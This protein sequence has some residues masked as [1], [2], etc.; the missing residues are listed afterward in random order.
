VHCV[1]CDVDLYEEGAVEAEAL[2]R[3]IDS[4]RLLLIRAISTDT[5]KAG[6]I[7]T[8]EFRRLERTFEAAWKANVRVFAGRC[9]TKLHEVNWND[10]AASSNTPSIAPAG[11][12]KTVFV[13]ISKSVA[14]IIY[15]EVSSL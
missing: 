2:L 3:A 6:D 15:R 10:S 7:S 8:S 5:A 1:P 4:A 14:P 11:D 13:H 12:V 9:V